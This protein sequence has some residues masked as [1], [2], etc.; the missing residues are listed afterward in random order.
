M[1]GYRSV[2]HAYQAAKTLVP[3]EIAKFRELG[4]TAAM[5]RRLGY[6]VTLRPDWEDVKRPTM[7][8]LVT[9]K[10]RHPVLRERLLERGDL[11]LVEG[12][13]WHDNYWG[14][15]RCERCR[16]LPDHNHLGPLLMVLRTH[17]RRLAP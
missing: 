16:L 10:F 2:E 3:E 7:Q 9:A 1:E 5:A 14:A 11:L 6:R 13:T 4:L 15:C 17:F 8:R 12:N